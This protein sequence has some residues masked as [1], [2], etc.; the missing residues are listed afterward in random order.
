[1]KNLI[2]ALVIVLVVLHNDIWFWNDESL[3]FG[4]LPVGLAYHAAFS[5]SAAL[6]WLIACKVA[7]PHRLEQ[8]A[9]EQD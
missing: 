2:I 9:D 6:L 7:W 8:W 1:M 5:I 4:F 3:L